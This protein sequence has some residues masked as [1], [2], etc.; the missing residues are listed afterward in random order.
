MTD[1]SKI[2]GSQFPKGSTAATPFNPLVGPSPNHP[3][4]FPVGTP[5]CVSAIADRTVVAARADVL[6]TSFVLGLAATPGVV[7]GSSNIVSHGPITLTEDQWDQVTNQTGGL[8]RGAAYYL[9]IGFEDGGIRP[10]KPIAGFIVQVGIALSSRDFFVQI[11]APQ[12]AVPTLAAA[13][14]VEPAK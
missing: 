1:V 9:S 8:T 2:S 11:C 5:V 12:E 13:S 6:E 4:R 7:G 3:S 10:V 14:K